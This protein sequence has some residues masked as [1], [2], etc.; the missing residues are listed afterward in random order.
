MCGQRIQLPAEWAGEAE[1]LPEISGVPSATFCHNGRFFARA[2]EYADIMRMC[3]L[4]TE[5]HLAEQPNTQ[6][7]L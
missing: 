4:A 2:K 1:N 6:N 7:T 5:R 3:K